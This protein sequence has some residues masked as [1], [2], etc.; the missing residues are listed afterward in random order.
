MLADMGNGT[1]GGVIGWFIGTVPLVCVLLK[2]RRDTSAPFRLVLA[3]LGFV[4]EAN[5]H[6]GCRMPE[7]W[8]R[9]SS[10]S[11]PWR[12]SRN[13]ELLEQSHEVLRLTMGFDMGGNKFMLVRER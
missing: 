5:D 3:E 1:A 7:E 2:S 13:R 12:S 9:L 8:K 11:V 10:R 4:G 6:F